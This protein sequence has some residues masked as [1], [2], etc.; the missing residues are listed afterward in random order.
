MARLGIYLTRKQIL[1]LQRLLI[2][3]PPRPTPEMEDLTEEMRKATH[4]V[5]QSTEKGWANY[6]WEDPEVAKNG[7][8]K[9]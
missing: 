7:N 4:L 5:Q 9:V 2:I 1:Y 3:N 8:A 6:E